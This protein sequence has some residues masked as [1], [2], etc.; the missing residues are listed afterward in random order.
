MYQAL[1]DLVLLLHL[2]VVIFVIGG[3]AVLPLGYRRGWTLVQ[4]WAFRLLHL[5]AIGIVVAQSWL[6][7]VCPLTTLESWLRIQ[8]GAPAYEAGFIEHWVQAIL[9]YQAPVWVFTLVYTAF[10]ALVGLAWLRYPPTR[11]GTSLSRREGLPKEHQNTTST[12]S[13]K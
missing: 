5:L 8:S 9:F 2:G 3:L 1:A 7:V 4:G 13:A 12:G 10:A 11:S 6:G